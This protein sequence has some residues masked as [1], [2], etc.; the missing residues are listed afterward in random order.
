MLDVQA[1]LGVVTPGDG[2][3]PVQVVA[4]DIELTAG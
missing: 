2:R 4:C 1:L 3:Q